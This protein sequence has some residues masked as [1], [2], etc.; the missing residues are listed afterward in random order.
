MSDVKTS[1]RGVVLPDGMTPR[2]IDEVAKE[3][4][5]E[6]PAATVQITLNNT[7]R[8]VLEFTPELRDGKVYLVARS[9]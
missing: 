4:A 1:Y 3:H 6:V 5:D 9:V 8:K 7:R 2:T